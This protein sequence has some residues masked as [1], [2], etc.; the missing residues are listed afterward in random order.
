MNGTINAS[1]WGHLHHHHLRRLKV[2][3]RRLLLIGLLEPGQLDIGI[4]ASRAV[5]GPAG[6]M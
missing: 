5:L 3:R 1:R 2:H 6:A 4:A